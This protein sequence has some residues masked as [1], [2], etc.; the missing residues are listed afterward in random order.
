MSELV[1][2]HLDDGAAVLVEVEDSVSP[3]LARALTGH[4]SWVRGVAFSPDGRWLASGSADG[5]ARLWNTGFTSWVTAGCRLVNRNLSQSEWN[6]LAPG[7][8]YERTCPDLPAGQD[9]PHD[10]PAAQYADG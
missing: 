10:S 6:Q 9:S 2:F 4:A 5:N 8:P 7:L 1:R 3:G